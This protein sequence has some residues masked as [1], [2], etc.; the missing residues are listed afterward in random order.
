MV[1]SAISTYYTDLT[2]SPS[3][4]SRGGVSVG[5]ASLPALVGGHGGPPYLPAGE[6]HRVRGGFAWCFAGA[7]LKPAPAARH[8]VRGAHLGA[9]LQGSPYPP[10]PALSPQGG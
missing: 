6:E 7:G 4:R 9:P 5:Q 1:L 3:T 10:H 2:E 8:F